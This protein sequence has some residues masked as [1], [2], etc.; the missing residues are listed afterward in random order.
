MINTVVVSPLLPSGGL[1]TRLLALD[2][3]ARRNARLSYRLD[4]PS[5]K[6]HVDPQH[7]GVYVNS[8]LRDGA[9]YRLTVVAEDHGI[10]RRAAAAQLVV[11][12]NRSLPF[13]LPA[14][15]R[16]PEVLHVRYSAAIMAV[17]ALTSAAL[18]GVVV[19]VF[20]VLT[21]RRRRV[22]GSRRTRT[23]SPLST[24]YLHAQRLSDITPRSCTVRLLAILCSRTANLGPSLVRHL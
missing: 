20:I 6:F 19:L 7:G 14:G 11:V 18:V 24:N 8:R 9:E 22:D 12:V 13:P 10:V 1:V 21:R 5:D 15:S 3:D 17:G 2:P 16:D 4:Q 23:G